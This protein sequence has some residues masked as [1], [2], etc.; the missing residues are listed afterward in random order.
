MPSTVIDF[1]LPVAARK[2]IIERYSGLS[3]VVVTA[4]VMPRSVARP[5]VLTYVTSSAPTAI[6]APLSALIA[7]IE[8][9]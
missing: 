9:S 5:G 8:E 7:R 6:N 2:E 3:A 4:D 1:P